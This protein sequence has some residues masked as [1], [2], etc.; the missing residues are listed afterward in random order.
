MRKILLAIA[1]VVALSYA[2][3]AAA[4]QKCSSWYDSQALR[5][6]KECV[7]AYCGYF[8]CSIEEDSDGWQW[9]DSAWEADGADQCFTS[10]GVAKRWCRP[11]EK[12]PMGNLLVAPQIEWKLV[13]ARVV[14]PTS[15]AVRRHNS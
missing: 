5:W 7:Y 8:A 2:L 10:E 13:R 9:C 12:D 3:P 11:D 4:C 1:V 14:V 15:R 6:C